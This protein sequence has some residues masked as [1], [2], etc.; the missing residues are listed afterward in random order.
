MV[1]ANGHHPE[2]TQRWLSLLQGFAQYW[3]LW[4]CF[5]AGPSLLRPSRA[6]PRDNSACT[7]SALPAKPVPGCPHPLCSPSNPRLLHTQYL[8]DEAAIGHPCLAGDNAGVEPGIRDLCAGDP[9]P[10]SRAR[11]GGGGDVSG[12]I[13]W[14]RVLPTS[15]PDPSATQTRELPPKPAAKHPPSTS[16]T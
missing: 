6:H 3:V 1:L 4:V 12:R 14:R 9:T 10:G 13:T 15:P 2:S 11:G 16:L 8:Q 7:T 5:Q